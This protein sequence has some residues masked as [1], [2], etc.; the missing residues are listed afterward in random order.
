MEN[1]KTLLFFLLSVLGLRS[2]VQSIH[3]L[4]IKSFRIFPP[5]RYAKN[6]KNDAGFQA[7]GIN[8][9]SAA[10]HAMC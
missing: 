6:V 5:A 7:E 3:F 8:Q 1:R 9:G 2:M 10:M 4:T